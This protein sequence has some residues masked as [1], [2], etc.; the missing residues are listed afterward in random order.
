M[1][2]RPAHE[3][4]DRFDF[5]ELAVAPVKLR[6]LSPFGSV[7]T[8]DDSLRGP[9]KWATAMSLRTWTHLYESHKM[10]GFQ[11]MA[12]LHLTWP[13]DCCCLSCHPFLFHHWSLFQLVGRLC[14]ARQKPNRFQ[15]TRNYGC[16]SLVDTASL[17]ANPLLPLGPHARLCS[18]WKFH[19]HKA[20]LIWWKSPRSE[21]C[22][23][24]LALRQRMT[25]G[26]WIAYCVFLSSC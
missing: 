17:V 12:H 1:L 15:H 25:L 16:L 14:V 10:L 9:P 18:R 22:L 20:P 3:T 11:Q 7:P 6:F 8:F 23:A 13:T 4:W 21:S 2:T 5:L 26:T 19:R 24:S